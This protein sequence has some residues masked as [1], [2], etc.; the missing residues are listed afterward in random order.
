MVNFDVSG[1]NLD[2]KSKKW[3]Q[4]IKKTLYSWWP[5]GQLALTIFRRLGFDALGFLPSEK[6]NQ[7]NKGIKQCS[8]KGHEL[9]FK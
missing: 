3:P 9:E 2:E 4:K 5:R 1:S 8:H 6:L 7:N